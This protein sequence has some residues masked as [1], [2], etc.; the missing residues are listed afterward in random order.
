MSSQHAVIIGG[1]SGIGLAAARRLADLG[2]SVTIAGRDKGKADAAAKAVDGA[3]ALALDARNPAEL[4]AAFAA[5]ATVDHLILALGGNRG[6]GPIAALSLD[7]LRAPFEDKVFPQIACLQAAL[8][9]L[10]PQASITLVSA[11]SARAAMPGTAGLG[12]ANAAIE[13]LVPILAAELKPVRV[14]AVSPGV[15][16]TPWWDFLPADQKAAAFADF[17]TR[18]PVGRIGT[19][20]D[21][22]VAIAFLVRDSFMTGHVLVCDG[23]V[24]LGTA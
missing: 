1:T 10:A 13:A 19:A 5:M 24:R 22:A 14:N 6:V 18:T 3:T 8:P 20:D 21:V 2:L 12:S 9:V 16:D 23:G 15:I 4:G 11:V 17:A 7:D